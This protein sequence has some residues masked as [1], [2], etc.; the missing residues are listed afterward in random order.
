MYRC[1]IVCD[2]RESHRRQR[3]ASLTQSQMTRLRKVPKANTESSDSNTDFSSRNTTPEPS[4]DHVQSFYLPR[5]GLQALISL[6]RQILFAIAGLFGLAHYAR[7][8]VR[9]TPRLPAILTLRSDTRS[10]VGD[11]E[12]GGDGKVSLNQWIERNVPSL[13]GRFVPT[14]WLP[15]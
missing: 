3:L 15:K 10:D 12:N 7:Q 2:R 13:K 8:V 6:P 11:S 5:S 14:W 1:A 4:D 9:I